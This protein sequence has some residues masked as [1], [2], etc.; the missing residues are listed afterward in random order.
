[1]NNSR[2]QTHPGYDLYAPVDSWGMDGTNCAL[3]DERPRVLTYTKKGAGLYVQQR[4][5]VQS[6]DLLWITVNDYH[7]LNAYRQPTTNE[8]IDYVTHLA[9]PNNC[10]VGGDFN[11]HHAIFEPGV[12]TAHRGQ[13][14]ADWS[15]VSGMEYIGRP[16]RPTHQRGHVLD[17]TFSNIPFATTCVN[18]DLHSG[19]DHETQI[20]TIPG[21]GRERAEQPR[22]R[23]TDNDL[24]KFIGLISLGVAN[25]PNPWQLHNMAEL[26]DFA[27][28]LGDMIQSAVKTAG[29]R[30]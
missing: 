10:L 4:R 20:T 23:V 21:R 7:I 24:E 5:P 29:K 25:L 14:M 26:D 15:F 18:E 17:L 22:Y 2:T 8:V 27:A 16:G 19:S 13:E 9:A 12:V 28:R 1:M 30:D 11:V 3:M 6:R